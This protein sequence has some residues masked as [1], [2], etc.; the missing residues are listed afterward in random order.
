MGQ[1]VADR[2]DGVMY[3][4]HVVKCRDPISRMGGQREIKRFVC[5]EKLGTSDSDGYQAGKW[6]VRCTRCDNGVRFDVS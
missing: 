3:Q 6:I 5:L 2:I 1:V 4:R